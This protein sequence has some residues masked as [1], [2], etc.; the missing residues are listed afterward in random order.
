VISWIKKDFMPAMLAALIVACVAFMV[1]SAMAW[2]FALNM[3]NIV[4]VSVINKE[5]LGHDK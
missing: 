1:G 5:E 4:V 3:K 2:G